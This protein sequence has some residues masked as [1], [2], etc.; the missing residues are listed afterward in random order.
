MRTLTEEWTLTPPS[1]GHMSRPLK[2][3]VLSNIFRTPHMRT[4]HEDRRTTDRIFCFHFPSTIFPF[5]ICGKCLRIGISSR[6]H[7]ELMPLNGLCGSQIASS[8]SQSRGASSF[9]SALLEG[10]RWMPISLS[11]VGLNNISAFDSRH[12]RTIQR[13]GMLAREG[14]LTR[15][16]TERSAP[17]PTSVSWYCYELGHPIMGINVLATTMVSGKPDFPSV[18]VGPPIIRSELDT[19]FIKCKSMPEGLD[20]RIVCGVGK[21][22]RNNSTNTGNCVPE[23]RALSVIPMHCMYGFRTKHLQ[24]IF[25]PHARKCAWIRERLPRILCQFF[26][27]SSKQKESALHCGEVEVLPGILLRRMS[28]SLIENL[29][30]AACLR[31]HEPRK[32]HGRTQRDKFDLQDYTFA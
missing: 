5:S 14:L 1:L 32:R 19:M 9:T 17:P 30:C 26:Q 2:R 3:L 21:S 20:Y 18:C 31:V 10:I 12:W 4:V 11:A 29:L 23:K 24:R 22:T 16:W 25:L 15:G 8:L 27:M 6:I 13:R 28:I 7:Q